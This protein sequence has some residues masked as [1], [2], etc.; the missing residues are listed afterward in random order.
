MISY[1]YGQRPRDG[2]YTYRIAFA[3]WRGKSLGSTCLVKI[4][5][6][7]IIIIQNDNRLSGKKGDIIDKG[8]IMN[9]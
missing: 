3:E 2:V 9:M 6:D 4:K 7:S 1:S 5:G 8:I